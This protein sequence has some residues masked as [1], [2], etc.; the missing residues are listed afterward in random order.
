MPPSLLDTDI[1]SEILKQK[2]TTVIQKA[3]VYLQ[4]H[5][6]FTFSSLTR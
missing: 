5:L 6:K 3:A 4:A 2:N 1:L